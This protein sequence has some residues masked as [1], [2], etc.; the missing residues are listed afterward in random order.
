[1]DVSLKIESSES[2]MPSSCDECPAATEST[3]SNSSVIAAH[4]VEQLKEP[5]PVLL[6]PISINSGVSVFRDQKVSH[7]VS[8]DEPRKG[9]A[10]RGYPEAVSTSSE[11]T[12]RAIV[13]LIEAMHRCWDIYGSHERSRLFQNVQSE[14]ENLGHS[15]PVEKIRRK[16]NNLIVTYKRVKE[17][18]RLGRGQAKTSWEYFEMMDK[19]LGKTKINQS[20]PATLVGYAT[21]AK[22]AVRSEEHQPH[23]MSVAAVATPCL[24]PSGLFT[25]PS[26]IPTLVTSPLLCNTSPKPNPSHVCSTDTSM[27][28]LS[29]KPASKI[30]RQPLKR[31]FRHLQLGS[32]ASRLAQQQGHAGERT[33]LLRNFISSHEERAR[34]DE[35]RQRK[36]DA[37]KRRQERTLGSMAESMGRMATALE[38]IS[39]KQDTI[40]ALLQ[41]LSDKH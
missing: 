41:R 6:Y 16:W 23:S 7:V 20:D 13:H 29:P 22:T 40:I 28:T 39:S 30:T 2:I 25:T 37:H 26:P 31:R 9:T 33:A 27:P 36:K 12:H 17:R 14:L 19:V 18:S 15:L 1:M 5:T 11:F 21:T 34:L 4:H 3:A 10:A 32:V 24:L 35:Q 38:L 8:R